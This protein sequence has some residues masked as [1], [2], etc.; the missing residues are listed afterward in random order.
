MGNEAYAIAL[1]LKDAVA[2]LRDLYRNIPVN[3]SLADR[4]A[5][6]FKQ[7]DA[8]QELL[9]YEK[10]RSRRF[11]RDVFRLVDNE[12]DRPILSDLRRFL[13]LELGRY[14]DLMNEHLAKH[15]DW[16]H[17]LRAKMRDIQESDL[18]CSRL[19]PQKVENREQV[20]ESLEGSCVIPR[21]YLI[22]KPTF[23]DLLLL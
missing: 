18:W 20:R 10:K 11:L 16:N 8:I 22:P 12:P 2:D 13:M 15:D 19:L 1:Q 5:R 7:Q 6:S 14:Q 4:E 9:G 21:K 3:E 17:E 23:R